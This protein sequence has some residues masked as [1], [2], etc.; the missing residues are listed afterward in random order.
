MNFRKAIANEDEQIEE[1][2]VTTAYINPPEA[3]TADR[4]ALINSWVQSQP[5][6]QAENPYANQNEFSMMNDR[7]G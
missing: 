2:N 5:L 3:P 4:N 1:L 7:M 6:T